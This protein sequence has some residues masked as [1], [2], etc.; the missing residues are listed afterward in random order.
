MHEQMMKLP[1]RIAG[2]TLLLVDLGDAGEK[3]GGACGSLLEILKDR[4]SSLVVFPKSIAT[5]E[6]VRFARSLKVLDGVVNEVIDRRRREPGEHHDLLAMLM[7]AKDA[8]SGE[9]MDDQQLRDELM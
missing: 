5:P 8:D 6:N 9:A 1:L 7:E 2:Q 4:M 3:G